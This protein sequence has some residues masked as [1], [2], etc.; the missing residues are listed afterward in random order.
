MAV[1]YRVTTKIIDYYELSKLLGKIGLILGSKNLKVK[2]RKLKGIQRS[3]PIRSSNRCDFVYYSTKMK[4]QE[5]ENL[6]TQGKLGTPS[7][8]R[9]LKE[10]LKEAEEEMRQQDRNHEKELSKRQNK[11]NVLVGEFNELKDEA[12][13]LEEKISDIVSENRSLR[14]EVDR[15]KDKLRTTSYTQ[16]STTTKGTPGTTRSSSKGRYNPTEYGSL[17]ALFNRVDTSMNKRK[18]GKN[19]HKN[20]DGA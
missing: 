8:L 18:R 16:K 14:E 12:Q 20:G 6:K 1:N 2:R 5:L 15:L 10:A 4:A 19:T 17:K 7:D 3:Y 13:N 11:Y 9:L